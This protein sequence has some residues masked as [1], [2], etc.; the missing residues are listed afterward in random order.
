MRIDKNKINNIIE[1]IVDDPD[2]MGIGGWY[3]D[4]CTDEEDKKNMARYIREELFGE[5]WK[6]GGLK[7]IPKNIILF[8]IVFLEN[9]NAL[10]ED[11]NGASLGQH[12]TYSKETMDVDIVEGI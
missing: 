1:D 2:I 12:W 6:K 9:G 5:A 10:E 4:S 8:R 3:D 11:Y 7:N